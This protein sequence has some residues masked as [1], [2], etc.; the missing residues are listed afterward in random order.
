MPFYPTITTLL[1]SFNR[2]CYQ[3]FVPVSFAFTPQCSEELK[4]TYLHPAVSTYMG[5]ALSVL[6]TDCSDDGHVP[7]GTSKPSIST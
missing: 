3:S 1:L 4:A 2:K 6:H 7:D 5:C